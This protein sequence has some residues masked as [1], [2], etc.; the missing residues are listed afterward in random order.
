MILHGELFNENS[1]F[2]LTD[3]LLPLFPIS[4]TMGDRY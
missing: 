2:L 4:R 3:P 1:V